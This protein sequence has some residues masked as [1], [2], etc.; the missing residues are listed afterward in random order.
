[1]TTLPLDP[2]AATVHLRIE[3]LRREAAADGAARSAR[4]RRTA[5]RSLPGALVTLLRAS[6]AR[7]A[8][9]PARSGELCTTC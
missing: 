1:M 4:R 9:A 8:P 6:I 5:R 2:L 3:E 7:S